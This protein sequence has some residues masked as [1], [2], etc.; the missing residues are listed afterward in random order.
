[1]VC[2]L[3]LLLVCPGNAGPPLITDDPV[4]APLHHWEVFAPFVLESSGAEHEFDLPNIDVNYGAG[5]HLQLTLETGMHWFRP[6]GGR[7]RTGLPDTAFEVKYRFLYTG[8]ENHRFHAAFFPQVFF[9]TGEVRR[10]LGTGTV[11]YELPIVW[12]YELGEKSRIYGDVRAGI[13]NSAGSRTFF[14]FGLAFERDLSPRW[15]L[16]GELYG[17]TRSATDEPGFLG[18]N[19]GFIYA[20]RGGTENDPERGTDLLFSIGRAFSGR[21]DLTFYLGPRFIFR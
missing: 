18:F 8:R 12:L 11:D 21:P 10:G 7:L 6:A 13:P 2:L 14:F 16:T 4:P 17:Q 19:L 20:I 1:M 5:K 15:T 9:P 3:S